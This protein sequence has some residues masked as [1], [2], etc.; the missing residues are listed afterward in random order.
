[1]SGAESVNGAATTGGAS[2]N[3]A[4]SDQFGEQLTNAAQ[5]QRRIEFTNPL[6]L[7]QTEVNY[8]DLCGN[9]SLMSLRGDPEDEEDS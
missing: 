2:T 9:H 4:A 3:G 5:N 8:A 1:M 6:T 7:Q